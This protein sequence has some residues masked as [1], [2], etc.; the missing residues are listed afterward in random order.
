VP[1]HT[2]KLVG[3]ILR[4]IYY[5]CNT[6]EKNYIEEEVGRDRGQCWALVDMAVNLWVL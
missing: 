2:Y 1:I 3:E 6:E 4:R 5:T